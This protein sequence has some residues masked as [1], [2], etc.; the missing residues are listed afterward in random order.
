MDISEK[1]SKIEAIFETMSGSFPQVV[2]KRKRIVQVNYIIKQILI[3][4]G[5]DKDIQI[6]KSEEKIERI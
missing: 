6:L 2:E 4:L 3:L 5:I 1:K